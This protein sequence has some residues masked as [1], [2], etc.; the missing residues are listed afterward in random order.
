MNITFYNTVITEN[1]IRDRNVS[2]GTTLSCTYRIGNKGVQ[3]LAISICSVS[4]P[5]YNY[6]YIADLGKYYFL[7]APIKGDGANEWLYVAKE[8]PLYT[9]WNSFKN[10]NAFIERIESGYNKDMVDNMTPY[11]N[12]TFTVVK[13]LSGAK[14]FSTNANIILINQGGAM[15]NASS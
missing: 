5:N 1:N 2:N 3:E 11:E 4:V 15:S 7:E 13:K 8:D 14:T 9:L 6:C 10:T 12:D